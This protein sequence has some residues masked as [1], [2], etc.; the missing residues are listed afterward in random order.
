MEFLRDENHFLYGHKAKNIGLTV[1]FIRTGS[2][3][4]SQNSIAED[5]QYEYCFKDLASEQK[6][7][8][9]L[10]IIAI[11]KSCKARK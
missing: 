4:S 5:M 7:E 6:L 2:L 9:E 1:N 3:E 8:W 11:S 10:F